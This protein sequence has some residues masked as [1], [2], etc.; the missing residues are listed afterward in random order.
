M[1]AEPLSCDM[2]QVLVVITLC[3]F[4]EHRPCA[5]SCAALRVEAEASSQQKGLL[6]T[7]GSVDRSD[8]RWPAHDLA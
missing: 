6:P 5:P 7:A 3:S 4:A 1:P 2:P 8:R